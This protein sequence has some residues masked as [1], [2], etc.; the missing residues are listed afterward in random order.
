MNLGLRRKFT[1]DF[2][3]ADIENSIIGC[4][5]LDNY[6]LM[7]DIH[8]KRLIDQTTG[9]AAPVQLPPPGH[10]SI[11]TAPNTAEPW[12][13][14]L[15]NKYS[16]IF[17][18]GNKK[19]LKTLTSTQIITNGHP[20]SC[21]P[22]KL[23]GE[24]LAAA[25]EHFQELLA[26]GVIRPSS[27]NWASP[28]HL[29]KKGE[30]GYRVVGDYR[31]L[32]E[33][34]VKDRYPV[35]YLS[36]FQDR[37]EGN[38]IF[39]KLDLQAAFQ[40]IP[41]H[42]DSITKTAVT[43][44]FGLFEYLYT[45]FGLCGAAQTQQ[46]LMDEIFRDLSFA[47]VYI[48][49]FL[50]A[51]KDLEE[52]KKHLDEIFRRM[53][54]NQLTL[55]FTKCEFARTKINFLGHEVSKE[56]IMPLQEKVKAI[57]E[58]PKPA[59]ILSMKRFIGMANFYRKFL[60]NGASYLSILDAAAQTKKKKD[61]TPINWNP[62]LEEAFDQAKNAIKDAT[63]LAHPSPPAHL[64]LHVD[65]SD[66]CV[67]AALN[68]AT[69]DGYKPLGFF[70]K[71]LS[72]TKQ[73][74]STYDREL[75]AI[76]QGIRHFEDTIQ[77]RQL[78]VFT[79]HEPLK[80]ALKKTEKTTNQR[81]ARQ[82]DYISLYTRD[83]RHIAG[84]ENT[85]A[86]ALSRIEAIEPV[87][88]VVGAAEMEAAQKEDKE[89][90]AI[91]TGKAATNL[92][93]EETTDPFG[94]TI[95]CD[96]SQRKNRPI[97]PANLQRAV[98]R[99]IHDLAHPGVN[100]TR[101]LVTENFVWKEVN[102]DVSDYVAKCTTCQQTK[103][104]R[105]TRMPLATPVPPNAR[106]QELNV[107]IIG[108]YPPSEDMRYCLTIIDRFTRW[109]A[110]IP[111]KDATATTVARALIEGWVQYMGVPTRIITDQGRQFES[112]LFGELNLALGTKHLMTT[113]YRPQANGI[114]ERW[115]RT[116]KTAIKTRTDT[117]WAPAIPL[118][119][120]ALRC[121][122]KEDL[123]TT[124][125]EMV[126]GEQL[127][128]PGGYF[129]EPKKIAASEFV[130]QMNSYLRSLRTKETAHHS[131]E[132]GIYIPKELKKMRVRLDQNGRREKTFSTAV[133]RPV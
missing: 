9:L 108:P 34:T 110:A 21:R 82:L 51:S 31:R 20:V 72:D 39:T 27:S 132:A 11:V 26:Q 63:L 124:P 30:N 33:I 48:D 78:T 55:S 73:R 85:V 100:A 56:G 29:V 83:I 68:Q 103:I 123:K 84:E 69:D 40:Q 74:Y 65:A 43:T 32:N 70:S 94:N 60:K 37:L 38:T 54:E 112:N 121:T 116:L 53:D 128:L 64:V 99:Q 12:L 14:E 115:H 93:P 92:K 127:Q 77:G 90:Q 49:D 15:F 102:K 25:K 47:F 98:I 28:I 57:S 81:Q 6:L 8:N 109:P 5:F 118:I 66:T 106:F 35:P 71:R 130:K 44:Q 36:D 105:H 89:L 125:A 62:E 2:I 41:V 24:K 52:H 3:I 129:E 67:G 19:A 87:P 23:T 59:T 79:D 18:A 104:G 122:L 131:N 133:H 50:I 119:V 111:M 16:S 88:T 10:I 42:P 13:Q 7:V 126:Y 46:R 80:H 101:K 22:R 17:Q 75:E 120:L 114:I 91:L 58:Y 107:D 117:N 96:T 97:V 4:D 113:A 1:W 95:I 61:K 76:F 86:D 45:P